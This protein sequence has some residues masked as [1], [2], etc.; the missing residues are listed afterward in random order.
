M[1]IKVTTDRYIFDT[2]NRYPLV[3]Q[4][5]KGSWVWDE[6]RKK[7]LDFFSGLA[8]SGIG[9]NL[10]PVVDA[11]QKQT[12]KL[13]HSSNYYYNE[14]AAKLAE[15]LCQRSFAGKVFFCNS[16][17]EANEAAIKLARRYGSAKGRTDILVFENGF[18]G[19]TLGAL[20]ATA[21][22][23]FHRGFG[24]LPQGFV[25]A[26]LND[27]D[28]VERAITAYTTAILIEPVQGEGGVLPATLAFLR[29]LRALAH[30]FGLLLMF[31]EVQCGMGRTGDLFAYQTFG[32]EPDVVTLAKGLGGGMPIGAMLCRQELGSVLG[33]GDHGSTFGANPV[34][35]AAA[36]AVLNMISPKLLK[37]VKDQSKALFSELKAE[38]GSHPIVRDIRGVGLMVGMEL[39]VP[40]APLV[41]AC[42]EQGLLINCTQGNVLRF[43]PPLRLSTPER[44]FAT[45]V[46]KRV[47][48]TVGRAPS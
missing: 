22:P 43:L 26:P 30:R 14:P 38:F 29:G 34:C 13:I 25:V 27:L 35:C 31:D 41:Q 9:H 12:A 19:R 32:V 15:A 23:Q 2:Y 33:P 10:P 24:P 28:A 8:V 6:R 42:W 17:T 21:Q 1:T 5:A 4:R 45:G 40:G 47:F 37:N 3:I 20:A 46:L 18:H 48:R 11:V 7:Y 39:S 16:G 44:R 36:L